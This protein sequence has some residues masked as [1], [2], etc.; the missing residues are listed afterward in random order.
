MERGFRRAAGRDAAF[1]M[2]GFASSITILRSSDERGR[3]HLGA[4]PARACCADPVAPHRE[5]RT[6]RSAKSWATP[7]E[8]DVDRADSH[9]LLQSNTTAVYSSRRWVRPS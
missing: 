8:E 1:S 5:P 7:A 9:S 4:P 3:G 6:Q 2:V